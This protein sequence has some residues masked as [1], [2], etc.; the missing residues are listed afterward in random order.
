[1][2]A[3][4]LPAVGSRWRFESVHWSVRECAGLECVV[5][6]HTERVLHFPLIVR[7]DDGYEIQAWA[8]ELRPIGPPSSEVAP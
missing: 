1:M 5:V 8:G 2:N 6:E 3:G 7:F 4:E